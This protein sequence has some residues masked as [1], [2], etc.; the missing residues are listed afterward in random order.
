MSTIRQEVLSA[1]E[2]RSRQGG[3]S[4]YRL[5]ARSDKVGDAGRPTARRVSACHFD[6][7]SRG[8]L[9]LAPLFIIVDE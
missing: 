9:D 8:G 5:P 7:A 3:W 4:R 1:S 2:N 6:V